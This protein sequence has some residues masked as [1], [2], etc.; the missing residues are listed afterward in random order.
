M[1][2]ILF[3]GVA[4][5][6]FCLMGCPSPSGPGPGPTARHVY[7]VGVVAS[8]GGSNPPTIPVY[9]K[10]GTMVPLTLSPTYTNGWAQGITEDGSGNIYVVG[11][12]WNGSSTINGYWMNS[13]F[14]TLPTGGNTYVWDNNI[15]VDT[16]GNVWVAGMVGNTNPPTTAVYW[17][18]GAGPTTISGLHEYKLRRCRCFRTCILFRRRGNQQQHVDSL[19][20]SE[21]SG[22]DRALS[23]P[24]LHQ[25]VCNGDHAGCFRELLRRWNGMGPSIPNYWKATG[26]TWGAPSALNIV[27]SPYSTWGYWDIGGLAVDSSGNVD[28]FA[29]AG[30]TS[31][32]TALVYWKGASSTPTALSLNGNAYFNTIN[33]G[34]LALDGQGNVFIV[35]SIGSASTSTIPVYWE[36]GGNPI[37]L[38]MGSG[39]VYGQAN[40]VAAG[41]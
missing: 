11:G 38:P 32:F 36:N 7:I 34:L 5:I 20:L 21:R 17:K 6:V 24:Q 40:G 10:D 26:G 13:T 15:A 23:R 35:D 3:S 14:T 2:R 31:T 1:R 27:G 25:R 37:S 28:A 4:V 9:W 22:C 19:V 8:S 16:S 29:F 30:S 12:Q 33:G 39:N 18:N 41:P